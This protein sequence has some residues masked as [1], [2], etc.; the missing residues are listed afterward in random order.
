MSPSRLIHLPPALSSC[1]HRSLSCQSCLL[2]RFIFYHLHRHCLPVLRVLSSNSCH[3]SR[4]FDADPGYLMQIQVI[5]CGSRLFDA[6]SGY[7][8]RIQVILCGSRLIDADPVYLM[9]I[10]ILKFKMLIVRSL[11]EIPV[12]SL[13]FFNTPFNFIKLVKVGITKKFHHMI[14]IDLSYGSGA[15]TV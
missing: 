7:L 5:W 2:H 1:V 13:N 11:F 15:F 9:R 4:L 8:M 6:D 10:Q 12:S 14:G 3:G